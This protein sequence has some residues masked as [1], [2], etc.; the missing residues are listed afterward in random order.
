MSFQKWKITIAG[1]GTMGHSIAQVF[2]AHGFETALTDQS[3]EQL[4]RAKKMIAG[5]L[6]TLVGMGEMSRDDMEKAQERIRYC[7]RIEDAVSSADYVVETVSE[8]PAVK[9]EIYGFLDRLCPAGTIFA[10]NTSALNIYDFVEISHPERLIIAHWFNPPH[11]MPLVEIV[12]GP[13]TSAQTVDAV[14]SLMVFLGKTPAVMNQYV[15]GFIINR[16]SIAILR[17][18]GHMVAKGWTRPEDIDAAIVAT[19]GLRYAFEG[20]MELC[21]HVGWDVVQSVWNFLAPRLYS[22]AEPLPLV[23][24]LCAMGCLGVKSG[25]GIK[26]YGNQD[27]GRI[28]H[29]RNKKIIK[30]L[31]AAKEL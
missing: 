2:A 8:S 16:L 25:R 7:D 26:D 12:S 28:Q 5:N 6:D 21:D 3:T 4:E 31:R 10:S 14:K 29:E 18:A 22:G 24:D 1:A 17:E 15:P 27:I 23:T 19:F 30:M 13:K 20:P 11:I 9:R